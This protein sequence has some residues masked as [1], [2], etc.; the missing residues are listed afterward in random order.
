MNDACYIII[1][2]KRK[3]T[4]SHANLITEKTGC[5]HHPPQIKLFTGNM[6]THITCIRHQHKSNTS[7]NQ[8]KKHRATEENRGLYVSP[9]N[10]PK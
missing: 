8:N 7:C 1:L 5:N 4:R 9:E 10:S 3:F 2:S 6:Q